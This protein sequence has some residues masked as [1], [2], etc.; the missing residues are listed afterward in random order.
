MGT[1][2]QCFETILVFNEKLTEEEYEEKVKYYKKCLV[3][4]SATRIRT[5]RIGK[6]KLAYEVRSCGYGYYALFMYESTIALI[7]TK[8]DLMLRSDDDVIKFI[9]VGHDGNY[10]PDKDEEDATPSSIKS[11]QRKKPVDVFNL[12]FGLE[13]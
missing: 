7:N 13:D 5:E 1:E 9:T 12:I 2:I 6:K 10:T 3:E 8:L 11:E 4:L